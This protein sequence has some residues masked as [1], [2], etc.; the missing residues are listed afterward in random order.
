LLAL[1]CPAPAQKAP[2]ERQ[3]RSFFG[4]VI[5]VSDGDTLSVL[6]ESFGKLSPRKVRLLGVDAPE[7]RQ[8]FGPRARQF[9]SDRVYGQTVIVQ[10]RGTDRDGRTVGEVL[11]K[12][13]DPLP[14]TTRPAGARP[15][16]PEAYLTPM[17]TRS[18]NQEMV[19]AGLAW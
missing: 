2:Q 11:F 4:R 13:E 9:A 19:K 5:G 16:P 14:R 15:L 10:V 8:P 7:P 17:R 3:E 12:R 1:P 6:D 18:L